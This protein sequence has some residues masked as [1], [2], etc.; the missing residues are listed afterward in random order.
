MLGAAAAQLGAWATLT[1]AKKAFEVSAVGA[2]RSISDVIR[3]RYQGDALLLKLK[4]D[5][6]TRLNM[7]ALPV[8]LCAQFV[9]SGNSVLSESLAAALKTLGQVEEF[10]DSLVRQEIAR[11]ANSESPEMNVAQLAR[12]LEILI[13]NLDELLPYLT[14]AITT[15]GLLAAQQQHKV[16][17][18]PSR[19]MDASWALRRAAGPGAQVCH[20]QSLALSEQKRLT[21]VETWCELF[22]LC[23]VT[24]LRCEG[25]GMET[26][27]NYTVSVSQTLDDGRHHDV[28]ETPGAIT[29]NASDIIGMQWATGQ[30]LSLGEN[31]FSPA[32][33]IALTQLEGGGGA[34]T[35]FSE[36]RGAKRNTKSTPRTPSVRVGVKFVALLCSTAA[37]GEESSNDEYDK[38]EEEEEE[39][40]GEAAPFS[41]V[42]QDWRVLGALD[43]LLRLC[44]LESREQV[45][46]YEI[47]DEKIQMHFSMTDLKSGGV[48]TGLKTLA[49][50]AGMTRE[51]D[52]LTEEFRKELT[53]TGFGSPVQHS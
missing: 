13:K 52:H 25:A 45:P 36:T 51:V 18:S 9:Q 27:C 40:A 8:D 43:S 16:S 14:L 32:L 12:Q 42:A 2:I 6:E 10:R 11:A 44:T 22:P 19:I 23:T 38:E 4:D 33:L 31:N 47:P 30:S 34:T 20:I 1:V 15:V 29:F 46:H 35:P 49:Q 28:N 41:N 7:L 24:V 3:N 17:V 39:E 26:S 37:G 50:P 53:F 5:L 21:G 48:L